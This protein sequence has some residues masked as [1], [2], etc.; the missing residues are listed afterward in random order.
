MCLFRK[1]PKTTGKYENI[2][3]ISL[4]LFIKGLFYTFKHFCT[5]HLFLVWKIQMK[6]T[7]PFLPIFVVLFVVSSLWVGVT[8][9]V[10]C[11]LIVFTYC[12]FSSKERTTKQHY[13]LQ[14]YNFTFISLNYLKEHYIIGFANK[15]VGSVSILCNPPYIH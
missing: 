3:W 6:M 8:Y 15:T 4:W 12:S 10:L 7:N 5:S 13:N 9:W 1:Y 2:L 11:H 14:Y